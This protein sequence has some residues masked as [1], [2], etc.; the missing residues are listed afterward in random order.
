VPRPFRRCYHGLLHSYLQ[1]DPEDDDSKPIG[2]RNWGSLRSYLHQRASNIRAPGIAEPEWIAAI[3]ANRELL[4]EQPCASYANAALEG[5]VRRFEDVCRSLDIVGNWWLI[6]QFVLAQIKAAAAQIDSRFRNL[7]PKLEA[8]LEQH[9]YFLGDGLA[10]LLERYGT[11]EPLELDENL[12]DFA[13]KHWGNP[14]LKLNDKKWGRVSASTRQMV[15]GWLKLKFIQKF[16]SLLAEDGVNDQRRLEFWLGYVD[17]ISDMH[18]A[19]GNDAMYSAS[20]DFKQLRVE[21]AGRLLHLS[22]GGPPSNN[23]F[24][25]RI[26]R[27]VVVEFGETGNACFVFDGRRD[28]PF[29]LNGRYV[30][31]ST[32][33]KDKS[34]VARLL[35]IDRSHARW[36]TTFKSEL[37]PLLGVVPDLTPRHS[38]THASPRPTSTARPPVETRGS[39]PISPDAASPTATSRNPVSSSGVRNFLVI[40]SFSET[41]FKA[42]VEE[43]TLECADRR[44]QGGALWVFVDPADTDNT[45]QLKAWAFRYSQG[46]GWWRR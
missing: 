5:D 16:F 6:R 8:M 18:F 37:R 29:N 30:H 15:T 26:G 7:L 40:P 34:R 4:T 28:L 41:A 25:M 43:R 38:Q 2:K 36:E 1:Y 12:R 24:I 31:G 27:H 17:H 23:A 46:K 13:V 33:L 19:L 10:A 44:P 11:S 45:R 32:E 39:A 14:W 21:M 20:P 35:H 42:F 3:S 22:A 9:E